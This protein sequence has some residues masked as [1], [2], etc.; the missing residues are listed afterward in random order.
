MMELKNSLAIL[1]LG[2]E[3]FI[4]VSEIIKEGM[5]KKKKQKNNDPLNQHKKC[6]PGPEW[7]FGF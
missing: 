3:I 4:C 5:E 7:S 6:S 1:T 2:S